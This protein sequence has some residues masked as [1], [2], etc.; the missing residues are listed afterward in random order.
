MTQPEK[1]K[2][3]TPLQR[4]RMTRL[5]RRWFGLRCTL[6]CCGGIIDHDG[7]SVYWQC[8]DCGKIHR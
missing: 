2:P 6:Q 5:L 4:G 7:K 8:V 3:L 1:R